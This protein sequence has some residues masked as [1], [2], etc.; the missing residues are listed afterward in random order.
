[1]E[2]LKVFVIGKT[3]FSIIKDTTNINKPFNKCFN[4]GRLSTLSSITAEV[5]KKLLEQNI[6]KSLNYL[7]LNGTIKNC[8]T[9]LDLNSVYPNIKSLE[10]CGKEKYSQDQYATLCYTQLSNTATTSHDTP[11]VI[12]HEVSA[13]EVATYASISM[14]VLL[15]LLVFYSICGPKPDD[16]LDI[17]NITLTATKEEIEEVI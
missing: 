11:S 1:M 16:D 3:K 8:L 5:Y 14:L 17:E 10:V 6:E 9:M 7:L 12:E 13:S 2:T 15:I 4:D